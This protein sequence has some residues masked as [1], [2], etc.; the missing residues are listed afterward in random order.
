MIDFG[1]SGRKALICGGSSGLGY[2]CA[3]ALAKCGVKLILNSRNEE[4]LQKACNSLRQKTGAEIILAAADIT[5]DKGRKLVIEK[6]G[7]V[8]ILVNN[9]GGAPIGHFK[10]WDREDWIRAINEN[11][12][13][14][15]EMIKAVIDSMVSKKFGRIVNITSG[16][17]KSPIPELGLSNGARSGLT[18]FVAG[19]AREYA[20]YN[21]TINNLLPGQ[22]NTA[23][24]E[25]LIEKRAKENG[26]TSQ[27]LR[28]KLEEEN[29]SKR[30][31]E[32]GEFGVACAWICST[33]SSYLVG[34]N[35]L[36]DGGRFNS[37]F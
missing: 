32:I 27:E 2:G 16:S 23:R 35:I 8:D 37:T 19:I 25:A 30:F 9:A 31:G 13:T 34:Q 28:A 17:V 33:H 10:N 14:S 1:I 24:I 4:R 6:A 12:L 5:T 21:V 36:I 18:G 11:M 26:I 29:P 3:E 15:I 20:Q 7:D 22:F